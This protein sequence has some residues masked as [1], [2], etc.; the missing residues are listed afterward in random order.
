M[1]V[2]AVSV[3]ATAADYL[4]LTK[5]RLSALVL[6][7]T[8]GGIWLAPGTL[9]PVRL[10]VTLLATAGI[11]GAANALNC[12]I[13]RDSDRF[14]KRTRGRP[15]P[16]GRMDPQAA[17]WFGVGLASVSLPAL[18]LAANPLTGTLGFTALLSYVFVYTPMKPRS[19]LAMLV[20]AIPGALPPLMG[21]TAVTGAVTLPGVVLF[22]ILFFW[23]LPHF[24]AIAL[25]R[26]EEYAAAGLTSLP[27]E[28]GDA[29]ARAQLFVYLL[30]L[31]PITLLPYALQVAGSWYLGAAVG[32]GAAFVGL[33]AYGFVRGLGAAWAR[34]VFLLS[35]L[36]LS[37]LF[38]ALMMNGGGR[39]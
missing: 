18:V 12:F 8:A 20:G 30:T 19:W 23:Q 15:L 4:S 33:G 3:P 24:I 35:L 22:G 9:P 6:I 10:L 14:M 26:K 31:F 37:G 34:R 16:A 7:T 28:K 39:A 27:L 17:L 29:H 13:E 2:R 11:V 21:W 5:P 32:L 38:A 25:F 36:H 1:T